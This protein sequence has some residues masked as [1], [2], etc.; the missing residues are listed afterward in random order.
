MKN[1]NF[2][3][4]NIILSSSK[5]AGPLMELL[6]EHTDN[7]IYIVTSQKSYQAYRSLGFIVKH[8]TRPNM[9]T[10]VLVKDASE[11]MANFQKEME[12]L[13]IRIGIVMLDDEE[14][15]NI[16]ES[17]PYIFS[18]GRE[19]LLNTYLPVL[20]KMNLSKK[21]LIISVDNDASIAE[22]AKKACNNPC[23]AVEKAVI[24]CV[25]TSRKLCNERMYYNSGDFCRL[26]LPPGALG[27]RL[28]TN[29]GLSFTRKSH[30]RY[31]ESAEQ[32]KQYTKEKL[33]D[34]NLPHSVLTMLSYDSAIKKGMTLKEAAESQFFVHMTEEYARSVCDIVL[35]AGYDMEY[36]SVEMTEHKVLM[37]D[38]V[39]HLFH[40]SEEILKRGIDPTNIEMLRYKLNNHIEYIINKLKSKTESSEDTLY[41]R[42][43]NAL[44]DA[45]TAFLKAIDS[46]SEHTS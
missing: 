43:A 4:T 39:K 31:C 10:N 16:V 2:T 38:F 15:Q 5:I 45:K 17:S 46:N 9:C 41:E 37:Y 28:L 6:Q 24:H 36:H 7:P 25:V 19:S 1:C 44:I 42:I 23:I 32:M 12:R 13:D 40:S 18:S 3:C 20:D 26:D 21:H 30:I 29:A 34:I 22:R 8:E 33:L 11:S 27:F 14:L 35:T